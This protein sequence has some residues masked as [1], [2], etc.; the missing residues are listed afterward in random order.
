MR[1]DD[2]IDRFGQLPVIDLAT[3][4]QMTGEPRGTIRMQVSRW[5][6]SG[7][8][9]PLRRGLYTLPERHGTPNPALLANA[10]YAPS[11]LTAEWALSYYGLIPEMGVTYISA[12]PRKSALFDNAFGRFRYLH[13]KPSACFGFQWVSIAGARVRIAE[14]EKALL[15]VWHFRSGPWTRE[16]LAEMRFQHMEVLDRPKLERYARRFGVTRLMQAVARW[17]ALEPETEGSRAL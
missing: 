6:R 9:V 5:S 10:I 1:Y 11:Y 4:V 3:M 7:R 2:F 15:D 17:Q 13:M 8:L 14:P 16:R 12:S